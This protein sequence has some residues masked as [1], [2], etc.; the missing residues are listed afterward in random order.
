MFSLNGQVN[1]VGQIAGGPPAGFIGQRS[2]RAALLTS[3]LV[4]A[5]SLPL[6]GLSLRRPPTEVGAADQ[7][8]A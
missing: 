2:L 1:A 4:Q 8:G 5:C 6:L 7:V 3:G